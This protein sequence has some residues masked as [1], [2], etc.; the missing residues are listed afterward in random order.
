[1]FDAISMSAGLTACD[2]TTMKDHQG[3]PPAQDTG[4]P[5][6][7]R[8]FEWLAAAG[9]L[10]F[11]LTNRVPRIAL[12][13]AMGWYS[14]LRSP[15]L[16]RLSIAAWRLFTDLDL[17]D[18]APGRYDSVRS[19]FTRRLRPGA[20]LVE[21]DPQVFVSP[22]DAILGAH[23]RVHDGLVLQCK[24]SPY[25]LRELLAADAGLPV[26]AAGSIYLT[27]RL[28]SAMYHRFHAPH[29]LRLHQVRHIEGDTFNV[30]P[31]ALARLPAL[32]CRNER[33][34]IRTRLLAGG[35]EVLLV[36]VAAILVSGIRLHCIDA[37]ATPLR[38]GPRER[39]CETIYR[40]GD[41]MGWF[42]HGS[43]IVVIAPPSFG[44]ARNLVEGQKVRMGEALLGLPAA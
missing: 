1:M 16:T 29:D 10:N 2:D 41:E 22:C 20:R 32:F 37:G 42:E 5:S 8:P 24:G 31:P 39:L 44:L 3:N 27:L 13:R 30:N 11:A 40:K 35:H 4:R 19:V 38:G 7:A 18:A 25:L 14:G 12:S 21:A 28:T 36:P 34:V 9:S 6:R 33:A 26:P 15:L 43:T 23:G 17:S